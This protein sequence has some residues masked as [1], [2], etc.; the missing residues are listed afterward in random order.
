MPLIA[1]VAGRRAGETVSIMP[2]IDPAQLKREPQRP[3]RHPLDSS[4]HAARWALLRRDSIADLRLFDRK[5][6]SAHLAHSQSV[7]SDLRQTHK[8][9]SCKARGNTPVRNPLTGDGMGNVGCAKQR[10]NRMA[11]RDEAVLDAWRSGASER[12]DPLLWP[13]AD[14]R[15]AW[16]AAP[17]RRP[18]KAG[19]SADSRGRGELGTLAESQA[20]LDRCMHRQLSRPASEHCLKP[21]WER[22]SHNCLSNGRDPAR[23]RTLRAHDLAQKPWL[24]PAI[25]SLS[26]Y[27]YAPPTGPRTVPATPPSHWMFYTSKPRA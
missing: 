8:R 12:T 25:T 13:G 3:Q 20:H 18:K 19:N 1:G 22:Q 7:G 6:S 4:V 15:E 21:P 9:S 5:S 2:H 11:C 10:E 17:S 26:E 14:G 24:Q 16:A 23:V 27:A